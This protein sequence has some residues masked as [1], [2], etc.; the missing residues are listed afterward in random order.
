MGAPGPEGLSEGETQ[1]GALDSA[2]EAAPRTILGRKRAAS[3][4]RL[5]GIRVQLACED[6]CAQLALRS[7]HSHSS[8]KRRGRH[9]QAARVY[10]VDSRPRRPHSDPLLSLTD[11][12]LRHH[13]LQQLLRELLL[14]LPRGLPVHPRPLLWLPPQQPG[15]QSCPLHP[16]PLP[17]GPFSPQGP[18]GDTL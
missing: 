15:L 3:P 7:S 14:T 18:P 12:S 8:M 5:P 11:L 9:T 6:I 2:V 10:N 4:Q 17:A 16:Q 1:G 13:V